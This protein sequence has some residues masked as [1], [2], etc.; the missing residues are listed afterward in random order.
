VT[1]PISGKPP[2]DPD[3][4]P[5]ADALWY[6]NGDRTIWA[7]WEAVRLRPGDKGS[8]V[9]WIR[10]RGTD[11]K[12]SGRR[13][14]GGSALLKASIPCCYPSGFQ[15]SRVYLSEAGCWEITGKAGTSALT[16]VTLV[17]AGSKEAPSDGQKR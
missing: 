11:L 3:A 15:A 2:D 10:P 6:V 5:F 4:D 12:I 7:G 16:F 9:L 13:L 14:D 17:A 8:K 1:E